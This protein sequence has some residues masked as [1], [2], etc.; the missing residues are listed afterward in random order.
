M[1]PITII[2]I[3]LYSVRL[4]FIAE[5]VSRNYSRQI[6]LHIGSLPFSFVSMHCISSCT[7]ICIFL[8]VLHQCGN[9]NQ[10]VASRSCVRISRRNNGKS[11][12]QGTARSI[13]KRSLEETLAYISKQWAYRTGVALRAVATGT[14]HR[15]GIPLS[16]LRCTKKAQ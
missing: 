13:T 4:F 6:S 12:T 9:I 16:L 15:Q 14:V 10:E 3:H 11:Q 7:M 8:V 2:G 5:Q 1:G